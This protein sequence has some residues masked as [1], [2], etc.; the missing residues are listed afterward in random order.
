MY[1]YDLI[2]SALKI[3]VSLITRVKPRRIGADRVK[4]AFELFYHDNAERIHDQSTGDGVKATLLK[5]LIRQCLC[6]S[7][8]N[9]LLTM[10]VDRLTLTRGIESYINRSGADINW[11]REETPVSYGISE[12]GVSITIDNR[13]GKKRV[14]VPAS[15]LSAIG[16]A[17]KNSLEQ[18]SCFGTIRILIEIRGDMITVLVSD[19]GTGMTPHV[20]GKIYHQRISSTTG[21]RGE[22]TYLVASKIRSDGGDI[23]I[24]SNNTNPSTA[25]GF[26][27]GVSIAIR[28]PFRSLSF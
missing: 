28:V 9:D 3:P 11:S 27:R 12:R 5:E 21:G 18:V 6:A 17:V 24:A 1:I 23:W 15:L 7:T 20:A 2:I 19:D 14:L 10:D 16:N 4:E 22:G 25:N 13:L 26:S 8:E